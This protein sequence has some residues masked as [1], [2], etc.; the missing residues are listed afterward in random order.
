M[1]AE[2]CIN[3][4]REGIKLANLLAERRSG[5]SSYTLQPFPIQDFLVL[6]RKTGGQL[7]LGDADRPL[8]K[9]LDIAA[10]PAETHLNLSLDEQGLHITPEIIVD[11]QVLAVAPANLQV[12][13]ESPTW[14]LADRLLVELAN[15]SDIDLLK[16]FPTNPEL[17]I[18]PD[19]IE[20]FANQYL[21]ELAQQTALQGNAITW[22]DLAPEPTARL[23]LNE[24]NGELMVQLKFAYQEYRAGL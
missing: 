14:I 2:D 7:F 6:I 9:Y 3:C 21:L 24:T 5:Y 20:D 1:E 17:L 16:N 10:S 12:I 8:R 22:E 11:G 15:P 4:S 19:D 23:Y 13:L 18:P